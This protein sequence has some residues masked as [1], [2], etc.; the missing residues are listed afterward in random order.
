MK[1]LVIDDSISVRMYHKEILKHM[2]IIVDEAENGK[3]ALEFL[4]QVDF[5]LITLDINMS[6]MDGLT[7]LKEIMKLKPTPVIFT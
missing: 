2:D 1:A 6:I 5:D 7:T 3:E 4:E